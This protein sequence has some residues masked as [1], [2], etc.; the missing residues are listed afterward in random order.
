MF[1]RC[2]P[3]PRDACVLD[4]W[5]EPIRP[6]ARTVERS[7]QPKSAED[8]PITRCRAPGRPLLLRCWHAPGSHWRVRPW[9]RPSDH[10][11]GDRQRQRDCPLS[12][13]VRR[14][15]GPDRGPR[16]CD[17]SGYMHWAIRKPCLEPAD[18]GERD[19]DRRN[20]GGGP[21]KRGESEAGTRVGLLPGEQL[22]ERPG[23]PLPVFPDLGS[24][25]QRRCWQ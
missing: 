21:D 3:G 16:E 18:A 23:D 6:R 14:V 22:L 5:A 2:E 13:S 24:A 11:R 4:A 20:A 19:E 25:I 15:Q 1:A 12:P 7:R 8:E 9:V 10:E 17:P